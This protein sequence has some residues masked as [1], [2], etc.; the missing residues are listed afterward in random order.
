M[1]SFRQKATTRGADQPARTVR[2]PPRPHVWRFPQKGTSA[3]AG[4]RGSPTLGNVAYGRPL[5]TSD[6][7]VPLDA[8][9]LD[10][11][12]AV[13][14]RCPVASTFPPLVDPRRSS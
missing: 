5:S 11:S 1:S 6:V 8:V 13:S 4:N 7:P 3:R 12:V 10:I 14:D 2:Q 9:R